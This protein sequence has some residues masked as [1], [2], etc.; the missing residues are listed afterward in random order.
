MDEK[1]RERLGRIGKKYSEWNRS[2]KIFLTGLLAVLFFVA[3]IR[4]S[5][6]FKMYGGLLVLVIVLILLA[7]TFWIYNKIEKPG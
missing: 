4:V 3:A 1:L 2:M 5:I 6:D 7:A